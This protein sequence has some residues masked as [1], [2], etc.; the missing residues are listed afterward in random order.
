V[1]RG[2]LFARPS[3]RRPGD[4]ARAGVWLAVICVMGL[5]G[6]QLINVNTGQPRQGPAPDFTLTTFDGQM[7]HLAELRGQVVVVNFWASWCTPCADEAPDL[8]AAWQTYKD[9]GVMVVGVD[10][11]DTEAEALAYLERFDITYPNGPDLG[12]KI[13][14]AYRIRGVPE[15]FVIDREGNVVYFQMAPLTLEQLGQ[16]IEA[17]LEGE[18]QP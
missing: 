3:D 4:W 8:E 9:Q 13:A 14:Q 5:L 18:G 2:S 10:Y 17:A 12:T 6:W 16:A 7:I 11:L 15:T 1:S